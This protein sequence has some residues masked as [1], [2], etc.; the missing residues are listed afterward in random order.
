ML[1]A[2]AKLGEKGREEKEFLKQVLERGKRLYDVGD[3][4]KRETLS[5]PILSTAI[6]HYQNQGILTTRD[7]DEGKRRKPKVITL[8]VADE[9]SRRGLIRQIREFLE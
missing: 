5:L 2:A 8:R 1:E 7:F 3:L 6:K 4:Q 9:K